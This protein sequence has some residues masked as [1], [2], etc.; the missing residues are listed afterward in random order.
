MILEPEPRP[1]CMPEVVALLSNYE[2]DGDTLWV[3]IEDEER[4]GYDLYQ[5]TGLE[6][7]TCQPTLAL[8]WVEFVRND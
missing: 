2:S 7:G 4:G 5:V 8:A 1:L 6:P 3:R